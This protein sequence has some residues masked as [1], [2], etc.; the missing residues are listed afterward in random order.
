MIKE[1]IVDPILYCTVYIHRYRSARRML[2]RKSTNLEG[3]IETDLSSSASFSAINIQCWQKT[4]LYREINVAF[5][6]KPRYMG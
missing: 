3:Y 1:R 4:P 6:A 2:A 5:F